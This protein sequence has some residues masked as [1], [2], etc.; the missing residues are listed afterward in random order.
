MVHPVRLEVYSRTCTCDVVQLA[1][2]CTALRLGIVPGRIDASSKQRCYGRILPG[3][4]ALR[5][6]WAIRLV[7]ACRHRARLKRE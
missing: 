4:G 1:L 2:H 6:G 7:V 5:L 3:Q